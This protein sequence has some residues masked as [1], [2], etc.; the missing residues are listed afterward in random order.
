MIDNVKILMT[1]ENTQDPLYIQ[2]SLLYGIR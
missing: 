1:F 2:N